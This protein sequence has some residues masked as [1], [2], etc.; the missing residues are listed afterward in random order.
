[1]HELTENLLFYVVGDFRPVFQVPLEPVLKGVPEKYSERMAF[2]N[3]S[4]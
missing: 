3:F 2:F 4:L 1:M